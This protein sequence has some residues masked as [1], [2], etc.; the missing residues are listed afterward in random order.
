MGGGEYS[1]YVRQFLDLCGISDVIGKVVDD[2]FKRP[3]DGYVSI[4]E[5]VEKLSEESALVI[6]FFDYNIVRS[7]MKLFRRRIKHLYDFRINCVNGKLLYWDYDSI[8]RNFEKYQKTYGLLSDERSKRTM[9][10]FLR[11]AVN[12]EFDNLW[13]NCYM[14]GAYFN[15]IIENEDICN[16]VD[17]GA[18]DGKELMQFT[19]LYPHYKKILA[20]EPDRTN[21]EALKQNV[22]FNHIKNVEVVEKGVSNRSG[23]LSFSE[24]AGEASCICEDGAITIPVVTLDELLEGYDDSTFIKMDIEGSEIPALEGAKEFISRTHPSL[25]ICVYHKEDDLITI[26]QY[27]DSLV[28]NGTYDYY[29]GFHGNSISELVFYALPNNKE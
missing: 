19:E 10:L 7:K 24:G 12:G 2:K 5:Y 9:D 23:C 21:I 25:A 13:D 22:S 14:K 28:P 15:S 3:G 29:L 8:S 4:S 20:I 1:S 27:I 26:P 11:A 6:G 16:L 17:C 18:C